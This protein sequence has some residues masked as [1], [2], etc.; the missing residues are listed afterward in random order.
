MKHT[1]YTTLQGLELDLASLTPEH[2]GGQVLSEGQA[3]GL[4][5]LLG[6]NGWAPGDDSIRLAHRGPPVQL[7]MGYYQLSAGGPLLKYLWHNVLGLIQC[8]S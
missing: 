6:N 3:V 7:A 4:A 8:H 1:I 5:H 2:A